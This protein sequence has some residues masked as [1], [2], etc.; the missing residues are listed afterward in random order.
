MT[1]MSLS[2][3]IVGACRLRPEAERGS[4][5]TAVDEAELSFLW[6]LHC[7]PNRQ[8]TCLDARLLSL[9]VAADRVFGGR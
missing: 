6:I 4:G 1:M 8:P 5:Q 3:A 7:A 9:V 2:D